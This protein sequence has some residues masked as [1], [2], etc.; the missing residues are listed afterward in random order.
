MVQSS[1]L[2]KCDTEGKIFYLCNQG[3]SILKFPK[4]PNFSLTKIYSIVLD[5]KFLS[6]YFNVKPCVFLDGC[7]AT[8]Q[9]GVTEFTSRCGPETGLYTS[10][11]LQKEYHC[12]QEGQ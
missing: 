11:L 9:H 4:V 5:S 12:H 1:K 8:V 2:K 7:N 3:L 6:I 10:G